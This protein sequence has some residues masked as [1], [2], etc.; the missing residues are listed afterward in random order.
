MTDGLNG[1]MVAWGNPPKSLIYKWFRLGED[2]AGGAFPCHFF[3]KKLPD[4]PIEID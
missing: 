4:F 2:K 1:V 3:K